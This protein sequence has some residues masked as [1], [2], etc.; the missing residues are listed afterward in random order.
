MKVLIIGSG[1]REHAIVWKLSQSP[2]VSKLFT[3]PGNA[4]TL[5]VGENVDIGASDF[6][7]IKS[8]VLENKIDMVVV[9]PEVPLV[10][11]INKFNIIAM[12][13]SGNLI[14]QSIIIEYNA[15]NYYTEKI[16]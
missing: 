5:E 10:E 11:G 16:E 14:E 4:G 8:F 3:A 12:D 6:T 15:P 13:K 1:G 7:A 9:G 2:L